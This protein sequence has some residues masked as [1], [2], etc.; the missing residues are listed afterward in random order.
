MAAIFV[1]GAL[2]VGAVAAE[3]SASYMESNLMQAL[4]NTRLQVV[5]IKAPYEN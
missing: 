4:R 1:S 2:K 3:S 5:G